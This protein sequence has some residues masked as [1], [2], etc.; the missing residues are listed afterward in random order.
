VPEDVL[1]SIEKQY[2]PLRQLT[3]LEQEVVA[4]SRSGRN[5]P[6]AQRLR[7]YILSS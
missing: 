5:D 2:A 3:E 1:A 4:D 7:E 6:L